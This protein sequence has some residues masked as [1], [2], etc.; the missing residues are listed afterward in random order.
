MNEF[1]ISSY[2][3]LSI[4]ILII[5]YILIRMVLQ[6]YFHMKINYINQVIEK[7]KELARHGKEK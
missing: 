7:A 1:E 5:V 6:T 4:T 3:Y 2:V